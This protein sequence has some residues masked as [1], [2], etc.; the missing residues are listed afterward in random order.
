[1]GGKPCNKKWIV[2][3][4]SLLVEGLH[5]LSP[6]GKGKVVPVHTMKVYCKSGGIG[7]QIPNLDSRWTFSFIT[8]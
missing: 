2:I 5:G 1:V 3:V 7:P 8:F 6:L 4:V